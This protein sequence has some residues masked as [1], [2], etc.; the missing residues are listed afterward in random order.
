VSA[1]SGR[2]SGRLRPSISAYFTR[3]FD[4]LWYCPVSTQPE[5]ALTYA[6]RSIGLEL[7]LVVELE[8]WVLFVLAQHAIAGQMSNIN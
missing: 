2:A 1:L 5:S 7:V 3:G 6:A 4:A 8:A